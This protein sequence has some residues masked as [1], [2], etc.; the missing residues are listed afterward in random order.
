MPQDVVLTPETA[1]RV[2]KAVRDVER[3]TRGPVPCQGP[4]K[5]VPYSKVGI[6]TTAMTA[7]VAKTPGYG[8]VQ[9][10]T[11]NSTANLLVLNGPVQK[12]LNW[13]GTAISATPVWV[14]VNVVDGFL[15]LNG[16]DCSGVTP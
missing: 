7:R 16:Q 4:S 8:N 2:A 9:L 14:E 12:V 3:M 5:V 10:Y 1:R 11:Y 15:W 13:T 6:T